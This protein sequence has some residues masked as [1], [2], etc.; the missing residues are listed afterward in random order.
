MRSE[1]TWSCNP[2][3]YESPS[4]RTGQKSHE[5]LFLHFFKISE[6]SCYP[7]FLYID[8]LNSIDPD[9]LKN[10]L[11]HISSPVNF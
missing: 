6:Y 1:G 2:G 7:A 4:L 11:F 10:K 8:F 5:Q 3:W 9:F